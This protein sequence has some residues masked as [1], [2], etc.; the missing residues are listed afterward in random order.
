VADLHKVSHSKLLTN[1]VAVVSK[2]EYH[3]LVFLLLTSGAN[4]RELGFTGSGVNIV[5]KDL[6]EAKIIHEDP[7]TASCF[8]AAAG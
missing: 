1:L 5:L 2:T 3:Y 7:L 6:S 4:S 8:V